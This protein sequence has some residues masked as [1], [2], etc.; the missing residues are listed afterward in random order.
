MSG[1]KRHRRT[2]KVETRKGVL[3]SVDERRKALALRRMR[4]SVAEIAR[5]IGRAAPDVA[6]FLN[7]PEASHV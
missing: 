7:S 1:G 2:I 6:D 5:A 3:L 4:F